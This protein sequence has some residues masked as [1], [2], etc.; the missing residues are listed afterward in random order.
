MSRWYPLATKK[1]L[2]ASATAIGLGEGDALELSVTPALGDGSPDAALA[3]T[4]S[5]APATLPA[6]AF[7]RFRIQLKAPEPEEAASVIESVL[8]Q[9]LAEP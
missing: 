7:V 1:T 3:S 9:T 4:W 8:I 2:V 5:A 6:A